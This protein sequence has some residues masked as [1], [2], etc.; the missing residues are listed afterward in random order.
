[1][2][3]YPTITFRLDAKLLKAV[4][5]ESKRAKLSVGKVVRTA[6]RRHLGIE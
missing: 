4:L 3:K 1:V 2:K 6:L 5:T